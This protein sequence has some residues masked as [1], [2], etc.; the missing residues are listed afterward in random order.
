MISDG[1]EEEEEKKVYSVRGQRVRRACEAKEKKNEREKKRKRDPHPPCRHSAYPALPF[2]HLFI[3]PT[4]LRASS[5]T[6]PCYVSVTSRLASAPSPYPPRSCLIHS[7][8]PSSL[9]PPLPPFGTLQRAASLHGIL[10]QLT[11]LM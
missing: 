5:V 6:Y 1:E 7:F 8:P 2:S 9:S 4:L 11:G 3:F 10:P